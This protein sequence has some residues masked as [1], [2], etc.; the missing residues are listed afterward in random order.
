MTVSFRSYGGPG[1]PTTK[2]VLRP[3]T[4]NLYRPYQDV[5]DM[6][7]ALARMEGK[8]FSELAS[9]AFREYVEKHYPGNPQVP[10]KS[11][12]AFKDS[13]LKPLRIEAKLVAKNIISIIEHLEHIEKEDLRLRVRD[14]MLPKPLIKLAR[15]NLSLQ[16]DEYKELVERGEKLLE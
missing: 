11:F 4:I 15:L 8:S 13:R 5:Y 3:K 16:D 12:E 1:R 9:V 2:D 14:N 6:F 7:E 10:L